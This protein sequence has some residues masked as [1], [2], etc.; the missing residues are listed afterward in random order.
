[1]QITSSILQQFIDKAANTL[2]GDWVIIGGTVL[3]LIGVGFRV[4]LDIDIAGPKQHNASQTLAL[5]EIA[6]ELGLPVEAVNQAGAFFLHRIDGWENN[7]ALVKKGERASIFRP[8]V[9]LFILLK[10]G[11][12]SE[13]DFQDCMHFLKVARRLNEAPD[14]PRLKAAIQSEQQNENIHKK[15]R[16]KKILAAL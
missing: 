12:L 10:I 15:K 2:L 14:I 7:L 11:R 8:N 13:S 1:M 9:T 6:S 4:T 5:M 3:P 16:L